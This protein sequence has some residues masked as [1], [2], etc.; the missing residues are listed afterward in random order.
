LV[1]AIALHA[2]AGLKSKILATI[3]FCYFTAI[4]CFT[5]ANPTGFFSILFALTSLGSWFNFVALT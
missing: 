5:T 4:F 1:R 2:L 3:I